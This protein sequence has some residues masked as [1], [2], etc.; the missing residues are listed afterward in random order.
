MKTK[1]ND[2]QARNIESNP[3]AF[4]MATMST[5]EAKKLAAGVLRGLGLSRRTV[6]AMQKRLN[7]VQL[8]EVLAVL[9]NE[10]S[11]A[12]RAGMQAQAAVTPSN[13]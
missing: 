1:P 13:N 8:L 11:A 6:A 9:C 10:R 7:S 5:P 3:Y 4:G 2:V 12:G